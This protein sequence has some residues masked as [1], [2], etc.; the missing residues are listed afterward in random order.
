MISWTRSISQL[1]SRAL[2]QPQSF[3]VQQ[4]WITDHV[5]S[6]IENVRMDPP[7]SE[8]SFTNAI[9]IWLNTGFIHSYIGQNNAL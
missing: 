2:R 9:R 3:G 5:K 6:R 8:T 7:Q 1:T 4:R